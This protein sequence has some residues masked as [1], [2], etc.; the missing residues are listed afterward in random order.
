M[1]VGLEQVCCTAAILCRAWPPQPPAPLPCALPL[2]TLSLPQP[3][4]AGARPRRWLI[5]FLVVF[6]FMDIASLGMVSFFPCSLHLS[7]LLCPKECNFS[8]R[9]NVSWRFVEL[10]LSVLFSNKA[11]SSR[12]ISCDR[13]SSFDCC[14]FPGFFGRLGTSGKLAGSVNSMEAK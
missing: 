6:L 8:L 1:E 10:P 13:H 2:C 7:L 9:C 11:T 12:F 3:R 4:Q 14:V 5:G